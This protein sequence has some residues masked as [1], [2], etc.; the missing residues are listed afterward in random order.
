MMDLNEEVKSW[1]RDIAEVL[2]TLAVVLIVLK[3]LLGAHMMV[4]LVAVVSC[5]MLHEGDAIGSVSYGL[6]Q[7]SYPILLDDSC[8]YRYSKSWVN[9]IKKRMPGQDTDK[10]PLRSGFSV[11]DMILV[12]TPDGGGTILPFFSETKVGDVIIFNRDKNTGNEPIIHRVVGIVKV[13]DW[14]I[15]AVEGTLDCTTEQDFTDKYIRYVRECQEG[16]AGCRYRDYPKGS[17]FEFYITKGDNNEGTDQ[18]S[19]SI[20]PV[21][22]AQVTARGWLRIPYVGWLKLV[23]NRILNVFLFFL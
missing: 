7:I 13:K 23:L 6:A 2:V 16:T 10:F 9:W 18:C 11:G 12:I 17:E 8:S 21:T 5:S 14:R 4:P 20:L 19:A 3:L 15:Q 22:D 1:V